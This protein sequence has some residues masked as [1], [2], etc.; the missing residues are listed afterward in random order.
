LKL[1]DKFGLVREDDG[2][3]TRQN[4]KLPTS[5]REEE[6]IEPQRSKRMKKIPTKLSN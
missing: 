3:T 4:K 5:T 2:N 6:I 1:E